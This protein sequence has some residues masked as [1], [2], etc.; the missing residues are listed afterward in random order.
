MK[1]KE[2]GE[3]GRGEGGNLEDMFSYVEIACAH[4]LFHDTE[5][6]ERLCEKQIIIII[7]ITIIK[8]EKKNHNNHD[9]YYNK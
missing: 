2:R 7:I 9:V 1:R 8:I 4:S 3:R 5:I 6:C